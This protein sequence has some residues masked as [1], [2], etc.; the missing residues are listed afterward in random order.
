M[1]YMI[2]SHSKH[3][4]LAFRLLVHA[5]AADV[6]VQH[7]LHSGHLAIRAAEAELPSY[8]ADRF[9]RQA[10]GLL[11]YAHFAPNHADWPQYEAIVTEAIR[12]VQTRRLAPSEAVQFVT[13]RVRQQLR[14]QVRI[15]D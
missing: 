8:A 6:N 11:R 15:V 9:L 5:S 3:P 13:A 10:T 4:A 1:V 12:A 14:H 7:A 2:S